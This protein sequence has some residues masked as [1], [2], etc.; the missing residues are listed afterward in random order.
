MTRRLR[1]GDPAAIL[2]VLHYVLLRFSRHVALDVAASGYEARG[3]TRGRDA[4]RAL[5]ADAL[6]ASAAA[7]SAWGA[8]GLLGVPDTGL[9][10]ERARQRAA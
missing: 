2:P 3:P 6:P 5:K 8:A 1:T 4:A 7:R 10:R 9:T